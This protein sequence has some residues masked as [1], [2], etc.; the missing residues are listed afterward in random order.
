M[1]WNDL[2]YL[3][4]VERQG[5][6]AAAAKELKVTKATVSRR[7]AALEQALGTR[8]AERCP[9]GLT[10]TA[11]GRE[12]LAAAQRIE[13]SLGSLEASLDARTDE[14]PT[15]IVRLTAPQWLAARILIPALAELSRRLPSLGFHRCPMYLLTHPDVHRTARVRV[16]TD[17][18]VEVMTQQRRQIE[19]SVAAP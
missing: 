5:S 14:S 19:G 13:A 12:A 10:L 1:D 9:D 2:R 3:L 4:A 8:I 17:F 6:L 7:L 15:G 11:A 16:V 18:V